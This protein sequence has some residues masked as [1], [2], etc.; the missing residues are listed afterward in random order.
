[1]R[2]T[3]LLIFITFCLAACASKPTLVEPTTTTSTTTT[4]TTTTIKP[5][6]FRYKVPDDMRE[7]PNE[8]RRL[9]YDNLLVE[10]DTNVMDTMLL[11]AI[12]HTDDFSSISLNDFAQL[13][14]EMMKRQV[15]VM[16]DGPWVPEGFTEK[17]IDFKAYQFSY[18]V[19]RDRIFQRSVYLRDR[20]RYYIISMSSKF[21]KLQ[22]IDDENNFFWDNVEVD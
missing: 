1:M 11:I 17:N 4:T 22:V 12:R 19:G 2:R 21:G 9:D 14:Q 16:Y 13:D 5:V 20:Q 8:A 18:K 3:I 6:G 10:K 15:K 7:S